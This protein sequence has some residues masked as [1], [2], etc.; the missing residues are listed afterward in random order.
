MKIIVNGKEIKES[1]KKF[2]KIRQCFN[3]YN[4]I[5]MINLEESSEEALFHYD[6]WI[7]DVLRK[8]KYGKCKEYKVNDKVGYF[9]HMYS[10]KDNKLHGY[11]MICMIEDI[12]ENNYDIRVDDTLIYKNVSCRYLRKI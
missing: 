1:E 6:N 2:I 11:E 3:L 10:S 4:Y 7:K 12:K 5:Q 8:Y 9:I